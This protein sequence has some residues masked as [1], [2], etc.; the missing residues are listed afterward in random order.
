MRKRFMVRVLIVWAVMAMTGMVHAA[1]LL[2]NGTFEDPVV[3]PG[4]SSLVST[5]PGWTVHPNG[6]VVSD[7]NQGQAYEGHNF[8]QLVGSGNSSIW[9][10]VGT[11]VGQAYQLSFAYAPHLNVPTGGNGISVY[12]NDTLIANLTSGSSGSSGWT[13][14]LLS[15]VGTGHDVLTFAAN[16]N[17]VG[18]G[19]GLDGVQLNPVPLP[20]AALLFGSAVLGYAGVLRRRTS[21]RR[22]ASLV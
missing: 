20:G 12:W 17:A 11:V 13:R 15:V 21:R 7:R 2:V 4:S 6:V 9:Q 10:R 19:A 5:L 3:P 18:G 1:N 8:V 22:P 14:Y 16:G